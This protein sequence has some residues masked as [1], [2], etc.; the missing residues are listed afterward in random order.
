MIPSV[1]GIL[2]TDLEVTTIP[3]K[4]Y[5]MHFDENDIKGTCDEI[6][7][8]KQSIYNALSTQRYQYIIYSWN[9]G[10]ELLDLFGQDVDWACSELERRIIDALSVDDRIESLEGFNFDTSKKSSVLCSFTA[11][12]IFGS[13]EIEKVVNY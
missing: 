1:N 2:T 10:V 7:A 13:V 5:K 8:V 12:T 9:Y 11:N 6:E 3:S 4:S